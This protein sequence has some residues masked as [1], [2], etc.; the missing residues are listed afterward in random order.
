MF[1]LKL[2]AYSVK[3]KQGQP[4]GSVIEY[5]ALTGVRKALGFIPTP[6]NQS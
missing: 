2:E 6:I 4:C 1:E 3:M 5:S